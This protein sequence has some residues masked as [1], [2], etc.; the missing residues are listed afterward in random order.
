MFYLW[1][2][3]THPLT[4]IWLTS[5]AM[6]IIYRL[7]LLRQYRTKQQTQSINLSDNNLHLLNAWLEGFCWSFAFIAILASPSEPLSWVVS[8]SFT[9]LVISAICYASYLPMFLLAILPAVVGLMLVLTDQPI[10]NALVSTLIAL[11]FSTLILIASFTFARHRYSNEKISSI[12][13]LG[14]TTSSQS[15]P[16]S[17]VPPATFLGGALAPPNVIGRPSL[18]SSQS[19][20][21]LLTRLAISEKQCQHLENKLKNANQKLDHLRSN[22]STPSNIDPLTRLQN[23]TSLFIQLPR[24]LEVYKQSKNRRLA[25]FNINID[26]FKSINEHYGY[27]VGDQILKELG[28]R[29]YF[30]AP[31]ENDWYRVDGDEFIYLVDVNQIESPLKFADRLISAINKPIYLQNDEL[32]P[33]ASIGI[34]TFPDQATHLKALI[35][36]ADI[37][38][39]NA[40][41]FGGNRS[42]YYGPRIAYTPNDRL[43]LET[44]LRKALNTNEF[45]IFYQ[46]KLNL[47]TYQITSAE[48]L[49]RWNHPTLGIIKPTDFIPLAEQ[50]G[51]IAS[52]G[53]KVLE[54]A[55]RQAQSWREEGMGD[56]RVS[57]NLSPQQ[58]ACESFPERLK[59]LL[60]EVKLPPSLLELELTESLLLEDAKKN[61]DIL[62][63]IKELGIDLAIDDFGTGFS[64]LSYLKQLP[65][66]T[67]KIDQS[68]VKDIPSSKEDL[69]IINT[70]ISMAHELKIRVVAEG[71]ETQDQ[72]DI[73][74]DNGCDELQGYFISE[75]LPYQQIP[76]VI[77]QFSTSF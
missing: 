34:S 53:F 35:V 23:R 52:L 74:H 24:I 58:L 48:A 38:M 29:L 33:T 25:L 59:Q 28:T 45:E 72:H 43:M 32:I 65:V 47:T 67:V 68:F 55:C 20:S 56:I 69:T 7:I 60:D 8:L 5:Q 71:V 21:E 9:L 63:K 44:H 2:D 1:D 75:P 11:L 50:T 36:Q 41:H 30:E 15:T 14:G 42:V 31:S 39:A 49:V 51:M 22:G 27:S 4:S 6:L 54:Q 66:S 16:P 19:Q 10:F 64:S 17:S 3:I 46:P 62:K 77:L 76:D 61:I 13:H 12:S 57:V 40:K 18:T 37:A 26:R 70:I 73:L